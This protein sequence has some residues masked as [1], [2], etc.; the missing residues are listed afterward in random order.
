MAR[1]HLVNHDADSSIVLRIIAAEAL[2]HAA[3]VT[4][5]LAD[6]NDRDR[7]ADSLSLIE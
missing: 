3:A 7:Q 1:R 5:T 6:K 4:V 2:H